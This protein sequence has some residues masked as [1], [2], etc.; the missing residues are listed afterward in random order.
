MARSAQGIN[1]CQMKYILELLSDTCM[2]GSKPVKTPMEQNLRLSKY[3]GQKLDD[4]SSYRRLIGKLLYLIIT[5]PD[6]TYAVHRLSQFMS[7]PRKP[8]LLA[9][10]RTLQYLKATS[11]QGILYSTI[12]KLHIK[13]FA[14]VDWTSCPDTRRSMTG[15]CVFLGDSLIS[16][17]SKKQQTISRSSAEAKYRSMVVAL[18]EVIWLLYLL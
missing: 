15:F 10:N 5:R 17:K 6:I 3:E 14:D 4:P 11:G 8:H 2:L 12:S 7:Q 1:L 9:A 13:A 18:C 16:R